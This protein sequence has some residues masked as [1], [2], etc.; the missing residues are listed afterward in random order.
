[1]SDDNDVIRPATILAHSAD[2]LTLIF[3]EAGCPPKFR[4]LIDILVGISGGEFEGVVTDKELISRI[5]QTNNTQTEKAAQQW[6][7]R[8]R[9]G[10]KSWQEARN[11]H[12]IQH[13]PGKKKNYQKS[14][15]KLHILKLAEEILTEAQK[16]ETRWD[17]SP[18]NAIELAAPDV[19]RKYLASSR[20]IPKRQKHTR[21][22]DKEVCTN[23]STAITYLRKACDAL[24]TNSLELPQAAEDL[25]DDLEELV[26]EA[27][28][29]GAQ[30][31][32]GS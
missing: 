5:V 19:M 11:I 15:Y 22:A 20:I 9:R 10:L 21:P 14:Y 16:D 23:L 6:L 27:R 12:F 25:L 29:Y 32:E 13:F 18:H 31:E 28:S 2:V 30:A 24:K 8:I 17:K 4:S 1:M 3:A 26:E 7:K